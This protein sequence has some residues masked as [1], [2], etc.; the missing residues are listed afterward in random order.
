LLGGTG[1][2]RGS[3]VCADGGRLSPGLSLGVFTIQGDLDLNGSLLI[4]L[5]PGELGLSDRLQVGGQMDI[6]EGTVEFLWP[7]AKPPRAE[8]YIFATYDTLNGEF[9]EIQNLPSGYWIDYHYGGNQ[10]A[11]VIPEPGSEWLVAVGASLLCLL[12][13]RDRA[14]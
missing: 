9:A 2:V 4:D 14:V 5:D 8:A 1:A 6:A 10:I 11:V 3:A 13:K 7:L 12:M